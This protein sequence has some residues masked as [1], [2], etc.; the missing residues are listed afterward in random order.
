ME[1][2]TAADAETLLRVQHLLQEQGF[3]DRVYAT[4]TSDP[5]VLVTGWVRDQVEYDRLATILSK[6]WPQPTLRV[7]N[8]TQA[9]AKIVS[10]VQDLDMRVTASYPEAGRLAIWGI[11]ASD[12]VRSQAIERWRVDTAASPQV[13]TTLLLATQVGDAVNE[14][15]TMAGLPRVTVSWKD[16]TLQ[17]VPRGLN[18]SQ[19]E[20][21][22]A[23]VDT[24]NPTYM[25]MLHLNNDQAPK[26]ES[27]PFRI[28]SVVG[29]EQPWVMLED[30]TRIVIGGTHGAF[31]LKSIEDSSVV[32]D[33]PITAV[34]PR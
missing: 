21:L 11:T 18:V 8:E 5:E 10:Q 26:P 12:A 17:I 34:I 30:G 2:R 14:A 15:V 3:S 19:R 25:N 24:L 28:H 7:D 1:T 33:G 23:V 6:I 4:I 13:T 27:I 9:T 22:K 31:R 29:G 32:F 16:K 20:Q